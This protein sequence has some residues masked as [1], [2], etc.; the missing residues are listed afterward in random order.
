MTDFFAFGELT[1]PE[2]QSLPR[3]TPLVIPLGTGYSM[4]L[5]ANALGKPQRTGLL[6]PVPLG[7][8]R[9]GLHIPE[10]LFGQIIS[11]LLDSLRDDGFSQV[12][13]LTPQGV[14]LGLQAHRI[15]LEHPSQFELLGALPPDSDREK[16]ILIPIGHTEQHAHHLALSTD[17]VIIDA[18]ARGTVEAAPK[19]ATMLPV[20]PYG[21]SMHRSSFAGTLNVGGRAFEDFW[22]AVIDGLVSR[23][24]N[25]FYIV[26]GHGGNCSS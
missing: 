23:G 3:Q 12:Y 4:N 9:S 18:I 7:W 2:V 24:F 10:K 22:L 25:R 15:A 17:T 16:V 26:S 14:D 21:V 6:P 13:A 11:N 5:L 8:V 1:W 20:F 19:G